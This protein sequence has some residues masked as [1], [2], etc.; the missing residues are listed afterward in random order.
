MFPSKVAACALTTTLIVGCAPEVPPP[1]PPMS[2][3][4]TIS[5]QPY[6]RDLRTAR[7]DTRVG[8]LVML[9]DTGGGATL[10]V[11]SVAERLGCEPFGRDVGHRMTGEQVEFRRCEE[12]ELTAGPWRKRF[13]PVAVFDVNALLPDELPRLDGVL[14]LDAFRGSVVTID[15]TA[16][17][18]V[19]HSE[20]SAAAALE[21]NGLPIR[22]STGGTG[23]TFSAFIPVAAVRG[24]TW[25]L[26]DS[27]NIRGTLVSSQALEEQLL[28]LPSDGT[29]RLRIGNRLSTTMPFET[30]DLIIDG[31]LG[32]SF[33]K[34][35]GPL[36]L[37]LRRWVDPRKAGPG[38]RTQRERSD[39]EATE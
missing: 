31:A 9:V 19:V 23:R 35:E 33:L 21:R 16:G 10:I 4:I 14:A 36:T 28:D 13:E 27:G 2:G 29:I 1:A 7:F 6:F 17:V 5:L 24:D 11:P 39:K 3:A 32:T 22:V 37:D 34:K 38:G 18:L 25:F 8:P 15:W 12:L 20:A 26:L 30:D